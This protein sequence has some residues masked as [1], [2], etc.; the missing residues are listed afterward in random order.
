[1][2][3]TYEKNYRK[4]CDG[5]G[6]SLMSDV[7]RKDSLIVHQ[8]EKCVSDNWQMPFEDMY[9]LLKDFYKN[10]DVRSSCSIYEDENNIEVITKG[11]FPRFY[12]QKKYEN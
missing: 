4:K 5:N 9:E 6:W 1:M 3:I 12:I 2:T 7:G 8:L 11:V 10:R